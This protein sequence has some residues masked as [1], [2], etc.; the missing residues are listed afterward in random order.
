M[1]H[2]PLTS[3]RRLAGLLFA[4]LLL[5]VGP[6]ATPSAH[7]AIP[8]TPYTSL[9][10]QFQNYGNTSG[11]WSGGDGSESLKLSDGRVLWFFSDTY[12]GTVD[13]S[14]H[15][16]PFQSYFLHNSMVVQNGSSMS[17]VVGPANANGQ[18]TQLVNAAASGEW[19]WGA[20]Q[21]QVGGTVY[22]FYQRIQQAG[23]GGFGF[24]VNGV[25]LV[26]MPVASITDP[27]TYTK[28]SIPSPYDCVP[29]T[30]CTLWG[31]ALVSDANY[32]YIYGTEYEKVGGTLNKWLHLARVPKGNFSATWNYWTGGGWST[33]ASASTRM[34][35]GV[36]EAFSVTYVGGR[37]VLLTQGLTGGLAGN[38]EAYFSSTPTG[39]TGGNKTVL[40]MTPET[41]TDW[42]NWTYGYRIVP[43]LTSGNTIVVSYN[44]NSQ[45]VDSACAEQSNWQANVY[46]PRFA[47]MTLPT[48]AQGGAYIAPTKPPIGGDWTMSPAAYCTDNTVAAPAPKNLTFTAQAGA[49]LKATWTAPTPGAWSYVGHWRDATAGGA[50]S[51]LVWF[52]PDAT[53]WTATGLVPNHTYELQIYSSAWSGAKSAWTS[54]VSATAYLSTPTG[55][56]ASRFDSG[57]CRVTWNDSQPDVYWQV[58]EHDVATGGDRN[59][60]PFS[61]K[62]A[63]V[64]LL[65][66]SH[67]YQYR[68][69]AINAYGSSSLS[70][71]ATC[72]AF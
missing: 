24:Q 43:Y 72:A 8:V 60:G 44:V 68:I 28:V 2:R 33:S 23:S 7:A 52:T 27:T 12:Y 30:H 49:R 51:D 10:N 3:P 31:T 20:D 1:V 32:T 5:L 41:T 64:G 25:E 6:W 16:R 4:V 62:V 63:A 17:T 47:Q 66:P 15:R 21:M 35:N 67:A 14:G 56:Q 50:W 42:G 71:T 59:F 34:M 19:L 26:A 11:Q 40:Y 61:S 65:T 9:T 54:V 39:F 70:T 22:K 57:T 38:M 58:Y 46:R 53:E 48:S 37:Y 69:A 13:T 45:Y 18:R 36:A 29:G 55:V